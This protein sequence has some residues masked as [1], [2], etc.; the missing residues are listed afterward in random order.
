MFETITTTTISSAPTW[1]SLLNVTTAIATTSTAIF[2]S[3]LT[4]FD[5]NGTDDGNGSI[6]DLCDA[7]NP[8]FNC[9]VDEYLNRYMGLKQMPL[10]TAIWVTILYVG[11][12]VT[13]FIGNLIVCVVIV[14]NASMHTATNY[15]LFSLAV[16]DLIF[17][18]MGKSFFIYY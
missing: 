12:F 16:S 18:M 14:K 1:I 8:E 6:F 7:E 4:N 9:T 10:H 5:T 13:G 11:I 17:L 15:Y 3:N 2:D